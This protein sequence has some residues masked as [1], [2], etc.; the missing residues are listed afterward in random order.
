MSKRCLCRIVK[1][2]RSGPRLPL[3]D[4]SILM[5]VTQHQKDE[6]R[7]AAEKEGMCMTHYLLALHNKQWGDGE[8]LEGVED[9]TEHDEFGID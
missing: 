4:Q 5:R 8:L 6:I 7:R 2:K 3:R 1:S 9:L